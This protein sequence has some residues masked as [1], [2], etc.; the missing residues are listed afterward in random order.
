MP[1]PFLS[2]LLSVERV[3][4]HS[5]ARVRRRFDLWDDLHVVP[6]HGYGDAGRV[7]LR[8]RVLD[9]E[10]VDHEGELTRWESARLTARRYLSDEVPGA[11]LAVTVAGRTVE[12]TTDEDG[13][14]DLAV[15]AELA[16]G[17]LWREATVRLLEPVEA[18]HAPVE[19]AH[20]FQVPPPDARFLLI[21]DLDDTVLR[22][23]ATD[24]LRFA[25][26]VLLNNATTRE[27]FPGVGAFY[28]ALCDQD[29]R[30][31]NPVFYVSSSPWNLYRQFVGTL[32]HRNVP[33]GAVFLKDFGVDPGKFIKTG[34]HAHKLERIEEVLRF[35]PDLPA[36]LVGD[37]GQE[38]PEIYQRV[39][40]RFPGRVR[41]VFVRDVTGPARDREV[42]QITRD[43]E[44]RGVPMRRVASTVEAAEAAAELGLVDDDAVHRVRWAAER[45]A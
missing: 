33:P 20:R 14:Y 17:D 30:P 36:I 5:I 11:R 18:D 13:Y 40:A 3:V 28:R 21:S 25:R 2:A 15:E 1:N 31:T 38:D 10:E 35:Y 34:H 37:S 23:G 16:E 19:V 43:V 44:A 8:G 32:E 12:T 29:G 22:T 6:Y 24:K 26:V 39:V 4:D 45:E 9:D 7:R 42:D 27:V 41:A